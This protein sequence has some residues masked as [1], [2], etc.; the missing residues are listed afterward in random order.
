MSLFFYYTLEKDSGWVAALSEQRQELLDK[1]Q[2]R[3]VTVL[4]LSHVIEDDF[5]KARLNEVTYKGPLYFDWDSDDLEESIERVQDFM[6]KLEDRH[7]DLRMCR[8]FVTGG[9]GFHCE[10][11]M[12]VF[13]S[14]KIPAKGVPFLPYIYKEMA[15]ALYTD[16]MD[17]RVYSA[18][19]GRMWRTPNVMRE[20]G[21]FKVPVTPEEIWTIDLDRYHQ[22]SSAPRTVQTLKPELNSEMAVMFAQAETKVKD[23]IKKKANTGKDLELLRKFQG[24]LP[25][26][27]RQLMNGEGSRDG[28]GFQRIATQITITLHALGKSQAEMLELCD[29]LIKHHQGDGSRYGNAVRRRKELIRMYQ[30]MDGNPCYEY[31]IGGL[32]SVMDTDKVDTKDL[33]GATEAQGEI[34]SEADNADDNGMLGGLY[35]TEKGLFKA[36]QDGVQKLSDIAFRDVTLLADAGNKKAV[37]FEADVL[38]NG[39][40]RTR[41]VVDYSL[42]LSKQKFQPFAMGHMGM[43]AASDNQVAASSVLMRNLAMQNAGISYLVMKEGLDLIARPEGDKDKLDMVWVSPEAVHAPDLPVKYKFQGVPNKDGQY[44]TDLLDAPDMDKVDLA[45]VEQVIEALMKVNDPYTCAALLSWMTACFHRQIFQRYYRQFPLCQPFGQ[46]GSG[47]STTT[48]LFLRLFYYRVEALQL[49]ADKTTK[50][51]LESAIMSSASIPCV[52]DEYKPREMG[53]VRHNMLMSTFRAAY[54]SAPWQKGGMAQDLGSSLRDIRSFALYAPVLYIGE[55][56]ETQTACMERTVPIPFSKGS[57]E[58]RE[59]YL[60]TLMDNRD[61]LSV[62]GKE[63][64]LLTMTMNLDQFKAYADLRQMEARELTGKRDRPTFNLGVL[65]HGLDFFA[66]MCRVH[67]GERFADD[68]ANLRDHLKD[69]SRFLALEAMPEAAKAINLLSLISTEE[70]ELSNACVMQ[71]REYAYHTDGLHLDLHMRRCFLKYAT[72]VKQRGLTALFETEEAF[73]QGLGHYGAVINKQPMDSV[74][75][76]HP[77]DRIYRYSIAKLQADKVEPFK[78]A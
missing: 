72:F 45:G 43:T 7:V 19:K 31:S 27:L 70:D 5:D 52:I 78:D 32:K 62:I 65:L 17:M 48:E 37:G 66:D 49:N 2:P 34:I 53:T 55:T 41:E 30:Y 16:A 36:G 44:K 67:F 13:F 51:A 68:F 39:A 58:G 54:T 24:E 26:S 9:R 38:L 12:D 59:G 60:D 42:F 47:K 74:L 76:E 33:K 21:N 69:K 15:F 40:K 61:V 29:G 22:L 3:Y 20:N 35:M 71:G 11:P 57:L 4:D 56:M 64:V 8:W 77:M 10:I 14:G 50:Y 23:A 75:R 18:R 63:L 73:M 25:A 1:H 6:K 28:V 46:A